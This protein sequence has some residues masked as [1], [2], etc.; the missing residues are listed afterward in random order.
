MDIDNKLETVNIGGKYVGGNDYS[1]NLLLPENIHKTSFLY[2]RE[3]IETFSINAGR[4]ISEIAVNVT[5]I[6]HDFIEPDDFGLYDKSLPKKFESMKCSET[7][8]IE[9]N[10]ASVYFPAV[11]QIFC[12]DSIVGGRTTL[13]ALFGIIKKMYY[14]YL[15]KYSDGDKIHSAIYS[16]LINPEI[17]PTHALSLDVLIFYTIF[18]CGIF[19]EEK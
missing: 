9:F 8:K 5:Q 17:S 15:D 1:N 10:D 16:S 6:N 14:L 7:Y 13:V 4:Y 12:N 11:Y 2:D 19:N 3:I 18:S